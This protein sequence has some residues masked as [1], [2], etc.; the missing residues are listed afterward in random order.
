MAG[1]EDGVIAFG[2][3]ADEA[4]AIMVRQLARALTPGGR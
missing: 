2:G 3:S 1:H 4:G